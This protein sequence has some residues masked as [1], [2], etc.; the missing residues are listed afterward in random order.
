M[1]IPRADPRKAI[2]I[3]SPGGVGLVVP[4]VFCL[5]AG[6]RTRRL[7]HAGSAGSRQSE[8]GGRSGRRLCAQCRCKGARTQECGVSAAARPSPSLLPFFCP[9]PPASRERPP[10]APL[11]AESSLHLPARAAALPLALLRRPFPAPGRL[12]GSGKVGIR[13]IP[14]S[15]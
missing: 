1:L 2:N 6:P 4:G 15:C 8:E 10:R 12:A 14:R 3:V 9:P 11:Q 13:W 7:S 5:Y